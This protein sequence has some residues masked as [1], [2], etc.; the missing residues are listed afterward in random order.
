MKKLQKNSAT[1]TKDWDSYY[2][3]GIIPWRSDGLSPIT[4][5]YLRKYAKGSPLL[6]I[7]CGTGEEA[8][9]FVDTGFEYSGFDVSKEAVRLARDTNPKYRDAFFVSDFFRLEEAKKY[10][11]LYDKGVFHNSPGVNAREKFVRKAASLLGR[12]GIWI[13]VCGT[14]DSYDPKIPHGAVFLQHIVAA[15]EPYFEILE[16]VKAPYGTMHAAFDGWYC[17]FRR[18]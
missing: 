15:V 8:Q 11:V 1:K 12:D 13:T 16:V 4:A 17:V 5:R 9:T 14:A 3:K 2:E 7:G 6:E 10:S 18:R